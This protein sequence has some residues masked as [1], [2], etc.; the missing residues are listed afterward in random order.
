MITYRDSCKEK[1]T[2]NM[3]YDVKMPDGQVEQVQVSQKIGQIDAA[4]QGQTVAAA[5]Q[6]FQQTK[7]PGN[8][9]GMQWPEFEDYNPD[10]IAQQN[11]FNKSNNGGAVARN[12]TE[13][14]IRQI[15]N[16]GMVNGGM[17]LG[18]SHKI[19]HKIIYDRNDS[20]YSPYHQIVT[21]IFSKKP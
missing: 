11:K 1:I 5:I 17:I 2:N 14:T 6:E 19:S 9:A 8:A 12:D 21:V 20:W 13:G 18:K 3:T 16:E 4:V 10:A 7:G 15:S